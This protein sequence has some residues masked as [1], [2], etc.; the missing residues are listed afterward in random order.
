MLVSMLRDW[1]SF[2]RR[3][4]GPIAAPGGCGEVADELFL[5]CF[6][7]ERSQLGV[8]LRPVSA[9]REPIGTK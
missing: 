2:Q 5:R 4:G 3:Q 1:Q 8:R 9:F 6:L 7:G